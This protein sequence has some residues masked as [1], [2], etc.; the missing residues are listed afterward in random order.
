[1]VTAEEGIGAVHVSQTQ[2]FGLGLLVLLIGI[3]LRMIDSYVLTPKATA[4]L[5]EMKEARSGG[6]SP[7]FGRLMRSF[8]PQPRKVVQPPSWI[9]F[10]AISVGAVLIL[11]AIVLRAPA[12]PG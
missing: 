4:K 12:A 8:G 5:A 9:G 10:A 3:Q 1:M 6:S 11:H 2:F 7:T